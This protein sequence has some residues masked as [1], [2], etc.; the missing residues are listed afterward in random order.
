MINVRSVFAGGTVK[1]KGGHV[2]S[3]A[4][5]T[6]GIAAGLVVG[7]ASA[8]L[9]DPISDR[10]KNK[11]RK[12]TKGVFRSLGSIVDTAVDIIR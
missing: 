8:M 7:A 9:M 1:I 3:K 11:L 6:A 12:K 10:Q 2:M 5:F 4:G